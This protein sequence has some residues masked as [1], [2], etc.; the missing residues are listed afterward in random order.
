MMSEEP[1]Q[2]PP[3]ENQP[4]LVQRL[5]QQLRQEPRRKGV[6]GDIVI[7]DV[8]DK[9]RNVVVGKNNVQINVAGHKLN[10]PIWLIALAMLAIVTILAIPF[11]EPILDPSQMTSGMNI[12][13]TEF[14]QIDAAGR[15]RRSDLGSAISEMVFNQLD[16]QYQEANPKLKADGLNVEIWHDSLESEAKN[17][18]LGV[19]GGATEDTRTE[20]ARKLAEKINADIV[21]YGNLIQE[22]DKWNLHLDFYYYTRTTLRGEPDPIAGRHVLSEGISFPV[23]LEEQPSGAV[24]VYLHDPVN[25]RA[26]VLFWL[27]IA[28]IYD[29]AD[30]QEQALATLQ[31]AQ[32]N[33]AQWQDESG[34]A[35]LNF[36]IGREAFWLRHYDVAI[37][38]LQEAKRLKENYANAYITLGAVYYDRAQLFYV[39]QPLPDALIDCVSTEHL[40]RAAKSPN[41]VMQNVDSAIDYLQQ[42]VAIAPNSPWPPVEYPARLALGQAY[43]L[44]GQA[45]LFA[46]EREL[47]IPW[48]DRSLQ[49]FEI[50]EQAFTEPKQPE[51]LAWTHLGKAGTYYYQAHTNLADFQVASDQ[52]TKTS[53]WEQAVILF[54]QVSE[55]CQRCLDE[56]KDIADTAYQ[57]LVLQCGC[58]YLQKIAQDTQM[59]MEK[60]TE[61]Q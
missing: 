9:A 56:G 23:A 37:A 60:L 4:R 48:F 30:R 22:G 26:R 6:T 36:S 10:F 25:L 17:V 16:A 8:G 57:K 45:Y 2:T 29:L 54:K 3:S 41:E 24:Q 31:E 33:L 11:L 46:G 59:K 44:K 47:A 39:P 51:Y 15:V 35:L 13:I 61:E 40:D 14:G 12:A 5:W 18:R 49:E 20:Q 27:T 52:P 42:A 21:I 34:Q 43:R 53:K 28:L 50:V 7:G 19:L 32:Q 38:A 55:E 1:K 58:E